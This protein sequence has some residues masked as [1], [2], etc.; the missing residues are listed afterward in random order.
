MRRTVS[1]SLVALL[2]AGCVF[3]GSST[4]VE[5]NEA[6][7][8]DSATD[9]PNRPGR[10]MAVIVGINQFLDPNCP[11]LTACVADAKLLRDTLVERCGFDDSF[12]KLLTGDGKGIADQPIAESITSWVKRFAEPSIPDGG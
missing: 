6:V 11:P 12:T 4:N 5:I 3:S 9:Q 10:K 7:H 8:D 2:L 1:L